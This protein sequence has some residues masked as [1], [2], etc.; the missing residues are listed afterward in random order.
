MYGPRVG[1]A[2]SGG[3]ARGI[4]HIG[5]IQALEENGIQPQVVSGTSAGS[6]IAALYAAGQTP[7]EMLDFVRDATLWKLFRMGLPLDGL[8]KLTYLRD[9][10]QEKLQYNDFDHLRKTLFVAAADLNAGDIEFFSAGPLFDVVVA[11]CSLPLLFK[12]VEIGGKTYVDGGL[13]EN[14]PVTPLLPLADYVI[15]VNVMPN[16]QVSGKGLQSAFSIAI[17]CFELSLYANTRISIDL[18]DMVIEPAE[19]YRYHI[20][21]LNRYQELFDIGYRAAMV[22]MPRLLEDLEHLEVD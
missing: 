4:A 7:S 18:C 2:L 9:R 21:Q 20:F 12:P 16:V 15:G 11:S 10:L 14:L 3:G 5:V 17:R 1:L 19:L 22:Q 13:L 8:A 6:I